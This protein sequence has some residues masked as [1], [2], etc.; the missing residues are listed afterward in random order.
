MISIC[1]ITR[2]VNFDHLFKVLSA[3]FLHCK[4]TTFPFVTDKYFGGG[5]VETM[6]ISFLS[7]DVNSLINFS[8]H[9]WFW[10]KL[11]PWWL[12]RDF[13]ISSL[14]SLLV[15][16]QLIVRQRF[17]F[18]P[19]IYIL[20]YTIMDSWI[21]FSLCY[22]QLLLSFN[23]QIAQWSLGDPR[24]CLLCL[25]DI[26]SSF[27]KHFLIFLAQ[28]NI[29]GSAW[30]FL[31]PALESAISSRSSGSFSWRM[32]LRS[33]DLGT[34]YSHCLLRSHFQAFLRTEQENMY[35]YT[36]LYFYIYLY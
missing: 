18:Y 5:Y 31:V 23:I 30:T 36:H 7:L 32:I 2:D 26:S 21:L 19:F 29:L 4:I 16:I 28:Q 12:S 17:P 13:L 24:V 11:L 3:R 34:T 15:D 22:N 1:P 6:S 10:T 25:S 9:W 27:F 35:I 20:I 8:T 33:Q 14:L